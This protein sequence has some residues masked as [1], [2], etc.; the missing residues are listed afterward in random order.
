VSLPIDFIG[1]CRFFVY[2]QVQVRVSK[3]KI[4]EEISYSSLFLVNFCKTGVP[5]NGAYSFQHGFEQLAARHLPG[6]ARVQDLQPDPGG[7]LPG[8]EGRRRTPTVPIEQRQE[9]QAVAGQCP[10]LEFGDVS[11]SHCL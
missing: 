4:G 5:K 7:P 6:A 1:V 3:Q 8:Q 9:Q 11:G 10:V 2:D